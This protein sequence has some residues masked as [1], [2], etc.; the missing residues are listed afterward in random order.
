MRI[1]TV[2]HGNLDRS[3]SKSGPFI[4]KI[5]TVHHENLHRSSWKLW[6]SLMKIRT[7]QHE[8]LSFWPKWRSIYFG[9]FMYFKITKNNL[10][11]INITFII[12]SVFHSQKQS[13]V[14]IRNCCIRKIIHKILPKFSWNLITKETPTLRCTSVNLAIF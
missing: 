4:M 14:T 2:Q 3:T 12:N 11:K 5:L 9:H 8:N 1:S 6:L 7:I 13:S 10:L